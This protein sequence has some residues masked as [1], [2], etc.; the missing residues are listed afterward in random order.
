MDNSLVFARLLHCAPHLIHASLDPSESTTQTASRSVQPFCT[1]HGIVSV[2]MPGDVLSQKLPVGT[3][4]SEPHLI[5]DSLGPSESTCQTASRSVQQS[6]QGRRS[7]TVQLYSQVAPMCSPFISWPTFTLLSLP[8]CLECYN[9]P[10]SHS[11]EA[12]Q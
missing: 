1:A 9:R 5:H 10:Q 8:L 6:L 3:R 4:R 11:R 7:W 2:R 12:W